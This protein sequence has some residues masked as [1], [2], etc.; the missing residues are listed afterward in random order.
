MATRLVSPAGGNW[1]AATTWVGGIIPVAADDI[2][3]DATSGPLVVNLNVF[4]LFLNFT[5]WTGLLTINNNLAWTLSGAGSTST[6]S[7]A[8][9]YNFIGTGATQGRIAKANTAMTF[10]MLGTTPIP[11]FLN[12]GAAVLT[13]ASAL[14]FVNLRNTNTLQI[15]GGFTTFITG[16]LTSTT[17]A[18]AGTQPYHMTGTGT[19][20]LRN[21][22]VAAAPITLVIDTAGTITVAPRGI[23]LGGPAFNQTV[24]FTHIAGTIVNPLFLIAFNTG[25]PAALANHTLNLIAGTTW[26]LIGTMGFAN[27]TNLILGGVCQFDRFIIE[28]RSGTANVIGLLALSGVPFSVNDFS[29]INTLSPLVV[30]PRRLALDVTLTPGQTLTI[31]GAIDLNG[32]DAFNSFQTPALE[33]RS[34]VPGVLATVTVNSYSQFIS[35]VRFTDITCAGGLTVYGQALTLSN[36]VNIQPYT[37]PPGGPSSHVFFS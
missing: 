7:A 19:I 37:L 8:G 26:N 35:R 5:G 17:G 13:A 20:D 9:T 11:H 15:T 21:S 25:N 14:H 29:I 36:T 1:N 33:I 34:S 6:F 27:P 16:N 3:A 22:S 12:S 10:N 32:G 24:T 23:G 28:Y 31:N 2:R 18:I 30:P 4:A